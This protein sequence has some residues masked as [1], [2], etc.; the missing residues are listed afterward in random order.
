MKAC[1]LVSP[2]IGGG[3]V[4]LRG[5]PRRGREECGT[6]LAAGGKSAEG[7]QRFASGIGM[8][9]PQP[10][11]PTVKPPMSPRDEA[12]ACRRAGGSRAKPREW[13]P[14]V[15]GVSSAPARH[16]LVGLRPP[17]APPDTRPQAVG[18]CRCPRRLFPFRGVIPFR[19]RS[20]GAGRGLQPER[21]QI[22]FN[23]HPAVCPVSAESVRDYR[24]YKLLSARRTRG[25][26]LL[27]ANAFRRPLF[28]STQFLGS[29]HPPACFQAPSSLGRST[30]PLVSKHPPLRTREVVLS[31]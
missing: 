11:S 31:R 15:G 29:K 9:H 28:P 2:P 21:L 12:R 6:P 17:G 5:C 14:L 16:G 4:P 10:A 13:R 30:H 3:G 25:S 22:L 26:A 8:A 23:T 7:R 18:Q 27:E 24:L 19:R 20:A 1:A